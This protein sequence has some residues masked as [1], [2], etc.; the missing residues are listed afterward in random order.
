MNKVNQNEPMVSLSKH[1]SRNCMSSS[2]NS[3]EEM[4]NRKV[5]SEKQRKYLKSQCSPKKPH[6]Y[7]ESNFKI[8]SST[9]AT[10][11]FQVPP[12]LRIS[13]SPYRSP[14]TRSSAPIVTVAGRIAKESLIWTPDQ[15]WQLWP[16]PRP[17]LQFHFAIDVVKYIYRNF[18]NLI[19]SRSN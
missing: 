19:Q 4:S 15:V 12:K 11:K 16:W 7:G 13:P 14:Q 9:K 2:E 18:H 5:S 1:R 6:Y 3:L 10:P 17:Y 8:F